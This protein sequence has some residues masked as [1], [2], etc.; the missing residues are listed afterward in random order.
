MTRISAPEPSEY[1]PHF[2]EY[3][4]HLPEGPVLEILASQADTIARLPALVPAAQ[5]HAGY[6]PG[7][8]SVCEVVSHLSDLERVFGYRALRISRG[9]ATALPGF[10]DKAYVTRSG[11][12]AAALADLVQE[13]CHLRAAN[14]LLFARMDPATTRHLGTASDSPV[15][16][17]ALAYILAGHTHHHLVIFRE[18]Y[19]IPL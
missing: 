2:Q 8:W 19:K 12:N 17:R 13:L 9:D 15:S 1:D 7:K 6:A 18:R 14:L 10:D 16:V 11:A 4:D 3:L 5:A